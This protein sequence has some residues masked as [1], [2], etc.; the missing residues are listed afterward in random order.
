MPALVARYAGLPLGGTDASVAALADR[1]GTDLIRALDR[2]HVSL[3]RAP[4]GDRSRL[5]PT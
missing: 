4:S 5:L 3:L 2:G 1:V